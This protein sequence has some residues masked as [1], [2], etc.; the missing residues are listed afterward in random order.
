MCH[1][2]PGFHSEQSMAL[3]P[4]ELELQVAVTCSKSTGNWTQVVCKSASN[5]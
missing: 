2:V 1:T 5:D 3:E 4:L